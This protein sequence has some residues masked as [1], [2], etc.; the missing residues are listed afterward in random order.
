M[1]NPS[2]SSWVY[3]HPADLDYCP[4][5]S[6]NPYIHVVPAED[7]QNK[8]GNDCLV[9]IKEGLKNFPIVH[10][11]GWWYEL[12]RN[13][14]TNQPFLGPFRSEVYATNVEV[15]L[16]EESVDNQNKSEPEEDDEPEMNEGLHHTLV[17]I[18]PTGPG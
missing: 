14:K 5:S 17:V 18:D 6:M 9:F 15:T 11:Q 3:I 1:E 7:P 2:S 13:K 16:T 4:S 12:Y 8:Y 10:H